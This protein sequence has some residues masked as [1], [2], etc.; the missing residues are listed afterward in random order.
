M[1]LQPIS[2]KSDRLLASKAP[3]DSVPYQENCYD[4][5]PDL[6]ELLRL[7]HADSA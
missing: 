7:L 1:D 5:L 6:T 3:W 2:L 4:G